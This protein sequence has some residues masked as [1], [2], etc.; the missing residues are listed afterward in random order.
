MGFL[1][2]NGKYIVNEK[3]EK[4]FLRGVCFGGWLNMENFI[5]GYMGAESVLRK[6]IKEEL[7]EE[8][9]NSFFRSFLDN[10]IT[11]KDFIF[12]EE[13][14][15]T[16]VRIPFNYRHFEDDLNPG[17]FKSS[18]FYYLDK[19]V[20]WGKKHN[21]YLILDLHAAPG[22]QNQ[23]WHS[24]NPFGISL[25]WENKHFQDRVKNL[26][27]YIAEHY[28]NETQIAGYN[29]LNEPNAPNI[30]IL[31]KLYKEWV[32]AIREID[33]NHI[34]F[35]EGNR[36]STEF[37]GLE[38]PF[39]DNLVYSSH[40]YTVMTHRGRKYPGVVAGI[41][42]DKKWMEKSFLERNKWMLDRNI[43]SWI[44][45]FGALFDGAIESPTNSDLARLS[46]L[47]DQLEIFNMYEQH[48]TIW[49]YK[50]VKYQGLVIPKE[51]SEY[52][53]RI[54]PILSLKE[55]LGLDS[56]TSRGY[57][58][59]TAETSRILKLIAQEVAEYIKD[60]SLDYEH[61]VREFDNISIYAAISN[62]LTPLF[63]LQF[64]DMSSKEIEEMHKEAFEFSYCKK[65]TY[66]IDILREALR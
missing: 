40:N 26:W 47:R 10:F 48:W 7:G 23:G 29:L 5:T 15:A 6:A 21:I 45:E 60:F 3:G 42:V 27:L 66:L 53:R 8:R 1:R 32:K 55:K 61:F 46:A 2:V 20:E 43:P 18:G 57:G 31:N 35:L 38:E 62:F 19:C 13:I 34:I 36:Y 28:K 14:G 11:E 63:A 39:D 30:E 41:Y 49:T 59:L 51:D 50:D 22:W 33:K 44:G 24:D 64:S 65:R 16:V 12:L 58:I 52:I 25:L 37:D 4:V 17:D 9:Y 56:W 54:K